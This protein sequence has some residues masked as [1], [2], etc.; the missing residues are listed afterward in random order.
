[1]N[2]I[3]VEGATTPE[4]MLYAWRAVE[5]L[6]AWEHRCLRDEDGTS[7][8]MKITIGEKKWFRRK[9][10]THDIYVHIMRNTFYVVKIVPA[11]SLSTPPCRGQ[12]G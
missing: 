8:A 6:N 1:M 4:H 9:V 11:N 3:Y 2:P 7:A 12:T 10:P 5:D